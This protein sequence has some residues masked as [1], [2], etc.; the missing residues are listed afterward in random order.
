MM[1]PLSPVCPADQSVF[2]PSK[3]AP[4]SINPVF[5]SFTHYD[6]SPQLFEAQN[7]YEISYL[8]S[9]KIN[10]AG[11]IIGVFTNGLT[12]D[13]ARITIGHL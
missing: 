6:G 10:S 11:T 12:K 3:A 1:G 4:M 9:F 2:N 5:S 7:G 13:S 8:D